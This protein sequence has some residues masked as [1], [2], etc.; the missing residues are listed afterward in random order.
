[1]SFDSGF[2]PGSWVGD[3]AS[4]SL[5]FHLCKNG[6]E[7]HREDKRKDLITCSWGLGGRCFLHSEN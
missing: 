4:L 3:L 2:H 5:S 1:M 6:R 7:D